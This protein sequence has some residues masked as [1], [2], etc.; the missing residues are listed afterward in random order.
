MI[1]RVN[2]TKNYTVMSNTHLRDRG[3]SLKAK[4]LLSVMLSLPE[5]WDYSIEGLCKISL[6]CE[7]AIRS[8]LNELKAA[9][10]LIVTKRYPNE[11]KSHL[12]EYEYDVFE[13][14]QGTQGEGVRNQGVQNQGLQNG[15]VAFNNKLNTNNEILKDKDKEYVGRL[16]PSVGLNTSDTY[17]E[18]PC[19][20]PQKERS[21]FKRPTLEEV[22]AYCEERQNGVDPN[23][24]YDYYTSNGF[25]VGKNS[26]KD[27]K[28]AVR[29]WERSSPKKERRSDLDDIF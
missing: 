18:P 16:E 7:K 12:I 23:R 24:W 3:L 14:R 11:T 17:A 25:K 29:T 28:A 8:A 9:G 15:G 20:C 2:H 5:D 21:G 19:E 6:E 27:W 13:T 1:F 4:G 26:M 10:Y 22:M